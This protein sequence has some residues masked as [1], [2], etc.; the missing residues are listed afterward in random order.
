MASRHDASDP[1]A[2]SRA[3]ARLVEAAKR[4]VSAQQ[5]RDRLF[6]RGMFAHPAWAILL[7]LFIAEAEERPAT[8]ARVAAAA[9]VSEPVAVR[10]VA[11]LASARLIQ[12]V[13][14]AGGA[15]GTLLVLTESGRSRLSDYFTRTAAD[16]GG[17]AA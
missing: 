11:M 5:E 9:F 12:R 6:G 14:E 13:P 8:L 7:D 2:T 4:A 17:V 15:R 16:P 3:Q 1:L 10:C